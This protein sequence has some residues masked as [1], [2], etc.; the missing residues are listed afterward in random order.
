MSPRQLGVRHRHERAG[1]A[2]AGVGVVHLVGR[3]ARWHWTRTYCSDYVAQHV[4]RV[5]V[6]RI[7]EPRDAAFDGSIQRLL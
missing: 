4:S 2:V 5:C 7:E 6:T 1:A 3:E